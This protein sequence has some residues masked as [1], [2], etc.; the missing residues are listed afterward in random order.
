MMEVWQ[1]YCLKLSGNATFQKGSFHCT[2]LKSQKSPQKI[3][4]GSISTH[5]E[6]WKY[7]TY[8]YASEFEEDTQV[9]KISFKDKTILKH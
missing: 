8:S 5:P 1:K 9:I 4:E 3:S 6:D 2:I 7:V